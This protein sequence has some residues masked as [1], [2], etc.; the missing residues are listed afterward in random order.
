MAE[1]FSLRARLHFKHLRSQENQRKR[2]FTKN[3]Q[4]F[5]FGSE[6]TQFTDKQYKYRNIR[7]SSETKC[8]YICSQFFFSLQFKKEEQVFLFC[9]AHF[10]FYQ[11]KIFALNFLRVFRKVLQ[12]LF[13]KANP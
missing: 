1:I 9:K 3:D 13:Y 4:E 8:R 7:G 11:S 6:C 2:L 12:L 5:A 10:I